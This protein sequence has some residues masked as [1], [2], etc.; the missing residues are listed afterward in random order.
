MQARPRSRCRWGSWIL[1]SL[2]LGLLLAYG[3][4]SAHTAEK[5]VELDPTQ[6]ERTDQHGLIWDPQ[7]DGMLRDGSHD[8]FDGA[9]ELKINGSTF[10]PGLSR[11]MTPDASE[12]VLRGSVG[13]IRVTR[14]IRFDMS[15]GA[16]RYVEVLHNRTSRPIA[17]EVTL[18]SSLG[19]R[20]TEVV[21][22]SGATMD[23]GRLES[24]EIGLL[25]H[26]RAG[27]RPG[28]LFVLSTPGSPVEPTI[29]VKARRQFVFTWNLKLAAGQTAALLHTVVQRRWEVRPQ[30]D[31]LEEIFL[32]FVERRWAEGLPSDVLRAL[33]NFRGSGPATSDISATA[34]A[35]GLVRALAQRY[36]IQRGEESVLFL[37]AGASLRGSLLA[38]DPAPSDGSGSLQLEIETP[39]GQVR[40][41]LQEVAVLLG[42]GNRGRVPRLYLRNG[43]VLVG[44]LK[45]P[46]L[47]FRTQAGLTL[48]LTPEGLDALF[49]PTHESDGAAPAQIEAYVSLAGG[50]HLA[51]APTQDLTL[52]VATGWGDLRI[53]FANILGIR[54][55]EEPRPVLRVQ[56]EDGSDFP[57]AIIG[58]PLR[59]ESLRF[60]SLLVPSVTLTG[61][62]R[63]GARTPPLARYGKAVG[64]QRTHVCLH[65]KTYLVGALELELIHVQGPAGAV[66]VAVAKLKH[67]ERKSGSLGERGEFAW[68]LSNGETVRGPIAE[69][70]LPWRTPYGLC[71]IPT[72]HLLGI[73]IGALPDE[74][75]D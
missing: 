57:I 52:P 32:P 8:C 9:L 23:G 19:A 38:P 40:L 70:L 7:V 14:R 4:R 18:S 56:I 20:A 46:Q 17:V 63:H 72:R 24:G 69:P 10:S 59:F 3:A 54:Q 67:V 26:H 15:L 45:A 47:R 22:N 31:A 11:K 53:P 62:Q 25:V 13:G 28:V 16:A 73:R 74:E 2:F 27:S 55:T 30:G 1:P 12:L 64:P 60:G 42:G 71:Q 41:R 48:P 6:L 66:P 43:E 34:S 68:T 51:L 39:H 61:W 75:G 33:K 65:E 35:D 36:E 29:T 5:L 58:A 37:E 44:S 49:L 50:T 21:S